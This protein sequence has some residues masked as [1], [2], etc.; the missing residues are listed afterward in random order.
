M[1]S[2][3]SEV[4]GYLHRRETSRDY[5]FLGEKYPGFPWHRFFGLRPRN[6]AMPPRI[7]KRSDGPMRPR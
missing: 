3:W 6:W 4:D 2:D 5:L 1:R 7:A